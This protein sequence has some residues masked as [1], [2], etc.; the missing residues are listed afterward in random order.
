MELSMKTNSQI[1]FFKNNGYCIIDIFSRED[2]NSLIK[3]ITLKIINIIN[4][5]DTTNLDISKYHNYAVDDTLHKRVINPNN[6]FIT[7]G[8]KLLY[9][10]INNK[11]VLGVITNQ[12]GHDNFVL[13]SR[14]YLRDDDGNN[15]NSNTSDCVGF[16]IARPYSIAPN[17]VGGKHIDL[18]FAL[19]KNDKKIF[20]SGKDAFV[21]L[22][23]PLIGFS[24]KYTLRL[25]PKSHLCDH[26]IK[27]I[28]KQNTY[29]SPVFTD[30]YTQHFKFVRPR[31]KIGQ[32]ILFHPFLLHGSS[33]NYG[34]NSRVSIEMRLFNNNTKIIHNM[35]LDTKR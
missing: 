29:I 15:Y 18:L 30:K 31:L 8:N 17:D 25:S 12:W 3:E 23:T 28:V 6:R 5:K 16:R 33:Y 9:K 24:E 11:K 26:P 21:T 14:E 27:E 2:V 4:E 34:N 35:S 1:K 13:K 7:I 10:M 32:A 20:S 19:V 22:W